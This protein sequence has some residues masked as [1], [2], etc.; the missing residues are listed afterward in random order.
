[1]RSYNHEFG[2]NSMQRWWT[3]TLNSRAVSQ[4]E[5]AASQQ[6]S[7]RAA[8]GQARAAFIPFPEPPTLPKPPTCAPAWMAAGAPPGGA[9]AA[10]LGGKGSSAAGISTSGAGA[11]RQRARDQAGRPPLGAAPHWCA[12]NPQACRPGKLVGSLLPTQACSRTE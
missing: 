7:R 12:G 1:M 6:G 10:A 9:G 8:T 4:R 11:A 3:A 2:P 5:Q